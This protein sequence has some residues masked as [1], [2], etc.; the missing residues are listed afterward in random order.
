MAAS[1]IGV[2]FDFDDTLIP[3][4]TTQLLTAHN[5]DAASFWDEAKKLVLDGYDPAQAFLKLLLDN[6]GPN[7]R[8]GELT[9]AKLFE[10]GKGLNNFF[11]GIPELF[12]DLRR[13][14]ANYHDIGIEFYIVSGGLQPII[15]GSRLVTEKFMTGVY[16]CRLAGDTPEGYLKYTQRCVTFTEKTRYLFEINKGLRPGDTLRKPHLVNKAVSLRNRR[17]PFQNMI[18]IGDGLTD[19]PCFSLVRK[20]AGGAKGGTAFGVYDRGHKDPKT[21]FREFLKENRVSSLHSPRYSEDDD[22]GNNI[23]GA[24]ASRCTDITIRRNEA[25]AEE[26]EIE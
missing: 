9:N 7:K 11:P 14:V 26:D 3:D 6:I 10:F 15:E 4:S 24:V 20:G 12:T 1:T 16:G 23:R 17:I 13:E 19:V 25:E 8:L 21:A 5:I 18:Y 2:I 22:L